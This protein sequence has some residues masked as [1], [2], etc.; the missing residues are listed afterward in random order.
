[1]ELRDRVGGC[2][3]PEGQRNVNELERKENRQI[4][5]RGERILESYVL[6][7]DGLPVALACGFRFCVL[8]QGRSSHCVLCGLQLVPGAETALSWNPA[9]NSIAHQAWG[10]WGEGPSW[11]W[12]E[13]Q[14]RWQL[15]CPVPR[16][17]SPS[18]TPVLAVR[19]L[20]LLHHAPWGGLDP[21]FPGS[22]RVTGLPAPPYQ[23]P[24]FLKHKADC[25][26]PI[27]TSQWVPVTTMRSSLPHPGMRGSPSG[28][29]PT[30]SPW[31]P[32]VEDLTALSHSCL[33]CVL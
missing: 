27:Q 8:D 4:V 2:E 3:A 16:P 24:G 26:Y 11:S 6:C 20:L 25:H 19:L 18:G 32:Q 10:S 31:V 1:M 21:A 29:L 9:C 30:S 15:H 23:P 13:R 5:K 28:A 7:W 12:A 22:G 17:V 33:C 14:S